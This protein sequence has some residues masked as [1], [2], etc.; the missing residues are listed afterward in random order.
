[1][2]DK[3]MK[4]IIPGSHRCRDKIQKTIERPLIDYVTKEKYIHGFFLSDAELEKIK[5]IKNYRTTNTNIEE[6]F[7]AWKY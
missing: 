2:I 1:M 4:F 7:K 6:T 3:L 5:H